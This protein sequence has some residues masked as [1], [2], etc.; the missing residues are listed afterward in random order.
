[1]RSD[2]VPGALLPDYALSD[3]RGVHRRL[4]EPQEA[5]P[6]V[7]VLSRGGFCPHSPIGRSSLSRVDGGTQTK[8]TTLGP[9][10]PAK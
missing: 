3:H 1:M 4:S 9:R 2:I 10:A 6:L 7:L 8:Y 5:D